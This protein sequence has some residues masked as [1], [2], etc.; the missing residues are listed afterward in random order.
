MSADKQISQVMRIID[1]N[2]N[3]LSEGLRVMEE[4][5]R[6]ILNNQEITTRLKTIRHNTVRGDLFF[7]QELLDARNADEDVGINLEVS[8]E[9]KT[10]DLSSILVANSRRVQESLRVL[11]EI[12]KLPGI[13]LNS[14]KFKEARFN[15][16][17]I[18]RDIL[19]GLLRQDKV[20]RLKGIYVVVDTASLGSR[21]HIEMTR[22]SI[23]GGATAIQLRDKQT[24]KQKLLTI[25]RNMKELCAAG[26]VLFIINDYLDIAIAVNADGVHMGQNDLPV[27]IARKEL[28]IDMIVGCSARTLAEAIQG[29][30]DGAD[31]IGLGA[32]YPTGSKSNAIVIGFELLRQTIKSIKIPVVAI[33]GIN[34]DN[35]KDVMAAGAVSAA[36]ISAVLQADDPEKATRE[37]VG[38]IKNG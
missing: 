25:A 2:F 28:P 30:K 17:T 23:K 12:G 19:S 38:I 35:I 22:M 24:D 27:T 37:L 6:L 5:A 31:Y 34:K 32:I 26:N 33:G 9:S 10:K 1:A 18:E 13:H 7:N 20:T 21:S 36:V 8:G 14:D 16:Y 15:S 3:R 4:I 29:E 11:E